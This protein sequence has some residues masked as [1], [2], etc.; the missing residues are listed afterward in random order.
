MDRSLKNLRKIAAP[1]FSLGLSLALAGCEA[2]SISIS[3]PSTTTSAAATNGEGLD[4]PPPAGGVSLVTYNDVVY[5]SLLKD[6]SGRALVATRTPAIE[7]KCGRGAAKINLKVNDVSV[8]P[9]VSCS[10]RGQALS[11]LSFSSDGV[12]SITLEPLANDGTAT[13]AGSK[14]FSTFIKALG[15]PAPGVDQTSPY[16]ATPGTVTIT[17]TFSTSAT[18][19]V[20]SISEVNYQ[21]G[22]MSYNLI[23]GTYSY[24][25]TVSQGQSITL[26][27]RAVDAVGNASSNTSL[28]IATSNVLALQSFGGAGV[29]SPV[30]SGSKSIPAFTSM[31]IL[32]ASA[33]GMPAGGSGAIMHLGLPAGSAQGPQ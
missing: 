23:A 19:L 10:A 5:A 20:S 13:G 11:T 8:G 9:A 12:Y 33:G 14:V 32:R 3:S 30:T 18:D 28:L 29:A 15:P 16:I 17:G 4:A 22:T 21:A 25:L 27:F 1:A 24:T 7:L 26:A 31:P 2:N 6:S